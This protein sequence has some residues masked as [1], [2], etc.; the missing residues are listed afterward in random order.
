MTFLA[1][2]FAVGEQSVLLAFDESRWSPLSRAYSLL[3]TL[4]RASPR[5]FRMWNLSK[6][7]ARGE[8]GRGGIAKRLPHVHDGEAY[9]FAVSW[10]REA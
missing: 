2:I 5:C 3:R 8:R 6:T 10:D 9:F 7:M 1:E 4:S